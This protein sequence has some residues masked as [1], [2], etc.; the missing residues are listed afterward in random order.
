[1][2]SIEEQLR[3]YGDHIDPAGQVAAECRLPL[4]GTR[5]RRRSARRLTWSVAALVAFAAATLGAAA[6][7]LI[8]SDVDE[9]SVATAPLAESSTAGDAPVPPLQSSSAA[10]EPSAVMP[11]PGEDPAGVAVTFEA[12][13]RADPI[14]WGGGSTSAPETVERAKSKKR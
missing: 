8:G 14:Y 6:F 2:L 12:E 4:G 13:H 1:M 3:R 7:A 11:S 9:V 5:G 10:A